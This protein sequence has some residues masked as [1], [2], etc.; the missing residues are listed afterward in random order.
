MAIFFYNLLVISY[1]FIM[2]I[3]YLTLYKQFKPTLYM[4]IVYMDYTYNTFDNHLMLF[5][6]I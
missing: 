6:I 3:I 1:I 4:L 5:Y 2:L